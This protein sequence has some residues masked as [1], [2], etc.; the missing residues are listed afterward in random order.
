MQV[1]DRLGGTGT[2][3][4]EVSIG[5]ESGPSAVLS[6][7]INALGLGTLTIQ[8]KLT[9]Q[10]TG[11]YHFGLNS[12]SATA[13]KVVANGATINSAQFSLRDL[14]DGKLTAGTVFTVIDNTA[15]TP[16]AGTFNN[17]PDGSIFTVNANTF[18]ASY[19]GGDGNDLTLTVMP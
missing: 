8:S 3:A 9:F 12:N 4:G 15:A 18:Q 1:S 5:T 11:T 7:G 13:D 2:I 17:L 19:A 14:G 16:I 10:A 6:P